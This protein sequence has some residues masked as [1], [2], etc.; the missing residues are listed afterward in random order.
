M[1]GDCQDSYNESA[2]VSCST[3]SLMSQ[4]EQS[5]TVTRLLESIASGDRS[6]ADQLLPLVYDELHALAEAVFRR[7][8]ADHTLQPTA[9]VNEAYMKLVG[10][11]SLKFDGRKQFLALASKAMR[12]ILVDHARGRNRQK[13][14]GDQQRVALT[15]VGAEASEPSVIDMVALDDALQRLAELDPRKSKLVELRFFG[16]LTSDEAAEVLGIARSTA[17]DDWR[18]ARAWLHRE[19][20]TED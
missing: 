4:P 19:L 13:R 9:L 10:Q 15:A 16:G 5:Q 7:E 6:A 3:N 14:G 2:P 11:S 1:G 12:N 18:M 8:R 20:R 17:A